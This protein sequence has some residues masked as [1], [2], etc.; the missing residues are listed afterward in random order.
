VSFKVL[1]NLLANSTRAHS[2]S[3]ISIAVQYLYVRVYRP[4]PLSVLQ[5]V[6]PPLHRTSETVVLHVGFCHTP[7]FSP[8]F[9]FLRSKSV[10][11]HAMMNLPGKP[12]QK[13]RRKRHLRLFFASLPCQ[14]PFGVF[15]VCAKFIPHQSSRWIISASITKQQFR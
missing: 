1:I 10:G 11:T 12:A 2:G 3:R 13:N 4:P 5:K 9:G 7:P 15:C 6:P 8:L 14:R